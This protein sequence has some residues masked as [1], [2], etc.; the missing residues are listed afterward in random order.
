MVAT[1]DFQI[2]VVKV[3]PF[4]YEYP[5][6]LFHIMERPQAVQRL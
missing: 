4:S 2:R 5:A 1:D 3:Y 6:G